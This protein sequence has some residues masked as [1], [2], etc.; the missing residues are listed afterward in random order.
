MGQ[1]WRKSQRTRKAP[2]LGAMC[3]KLALCQTKLISHPACFGMV[4]KRGR[5]PLPLLHLYRVINASFCVQLLSQPAVP[6]KLFN[7]CQGFANLAAETV[8][9]AL[10]A[11]ASNLVADEFSTLGFVKG[12]LN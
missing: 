8:A 7:L 5:S 1:I 2:V 12:K 10:P 11:C 9:F 4:N 6:K 3:D